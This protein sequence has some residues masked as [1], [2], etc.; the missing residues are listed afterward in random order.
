MVS[1][2][3]RRSSNIFKD[4]LDLRGGQAMGLENLEV[5][6]FFKQPR[7]WFASSNLLI[8]EREIQAIRM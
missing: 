1:S 2:A 8:V 6:A 7:T 4:F 3:R 5:P